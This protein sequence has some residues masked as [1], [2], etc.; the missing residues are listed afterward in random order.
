MADRRPGY[1]AAKRLIDLAGSAILLAVFAP[2]F[3]AVAVAIKLDSPGP[4]MFRQIRVGRRGRPFRMVKFRTMLHGADESFL[5][6][7]LKR[8][9]ELGEDAGAEPAVL[10]IEDDPR[11]TRV[12]RWLRKWSLDELPNLW[13]VFTGSM[14]LVG[15]RPLVPD[16]IEI[17]GEGSLPRLTVKPGITGLAQVAGRDLITID[18]RTRHDLDYVRRRSLRLDLEI[19]VDTVRAVFRQPGA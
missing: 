15:P 13:N 1:D 18:E 19:M 16:E 11:V 10:R 14:S 3:A 5:T 7:H 9:A 2:L 8:L 12:G 6:E 4:V 17:M